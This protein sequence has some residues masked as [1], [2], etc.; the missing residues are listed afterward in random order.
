MNTDSEAGNNTDIEL[1]AAGS[2]WVV[3]STVSLFISSESERTT[4]QSA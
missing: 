3:A 4:D 1:E 2:R